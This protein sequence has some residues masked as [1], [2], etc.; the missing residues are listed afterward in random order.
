MTYRNQI[1][2]QLTNGKYGKKNYMDL[3][4]KKPAKTTS[5]SNEFGPTYE[6]PNENPNEKS[7]HTP[8][9]SVIKNTSDNTK[10][11]DIFTE[12]SEN[13]PTISKDNTDPTILQDKI[14]VMEDYIA[15]ISIEIE[16]LKTGQKNIINAINKLSNELSIVKN[17]IIR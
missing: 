2:K 16:N 3:L 7:I 6:N 17:K 13:D 1:L 14:L 11:E 10:M 8:P 5:L 4:K 12:Q 9:K 15:E